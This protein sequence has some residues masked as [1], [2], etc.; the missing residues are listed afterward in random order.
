MVGKMKKETR[1]TYVLV[2]RKRPIAAKAR[3][4]KKWYT[5]GE[6]KPSRVIPVKTQILK[7]S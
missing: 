6:R 7:V 3:P 5:K 2:T 4:G 1:F